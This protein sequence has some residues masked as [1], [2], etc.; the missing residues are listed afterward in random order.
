MISDVNSMGLGCADL[1]PARTCHSEK[2]VYPCRLEE[3]LRA[4]SSVG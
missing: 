1:Q 2:L 3:Q 4:R